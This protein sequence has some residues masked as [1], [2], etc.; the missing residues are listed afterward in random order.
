MRAGIV[1]PAVRRTRVPTKRITVPTIRR[2]VIASLAAASAV[3][4]T[5][6]DSEQIGA[7][8]VIDGDRFTVDDLQNEVQHAQRLEGFDVDAAGGMPAFQRTI[9]T[10]HIQHEIFLRLAE[11]EDIEVSEADIDDAIDEISAQAPGGDIETA[12]AQAGYTEKAFRAGVADQL[13]AQAYSEET[14]AD[15]AALTQTLVDLGDELGVEVNPRF[16]TW[17]DDLTVSGDTGSISEPA[18]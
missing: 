18:S 13:I 4:L 15:T 5:A 3:A 11:D 6:C 2:I 17:G 1:R 10:R 16:G 7:A 14:G 9:L 12:L 8:V